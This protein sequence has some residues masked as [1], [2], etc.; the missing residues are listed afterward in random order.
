L[1]LIVIIFGVESIN[2]LSAATVEQQQQD[3]GSKETQV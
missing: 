3:P 1:M 2:A